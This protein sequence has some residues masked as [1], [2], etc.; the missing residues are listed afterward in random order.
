MKH[1]F[2]I[3]K[4]WFV[5]SS[6]SLMYQTLMKILFYLIVFT[7]S[8]ASYAQVYSQEASFKKL[9]TLYK[10]SFSQDLKSF[11]N[12]PEDF[13]C[14]G[15]KYRYSLTG[16]GGNYLKELDDRFDEV[17]EDFND[18]D[19]RWMIKYSFK[20]DYVFAGAKI[21]VDRMSWSRVKAT[22][23]YLYLC[24]CNKSESELKQIIKNL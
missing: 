1:L 14:I 16:K 12:Y 6:I 21:K 11:S 8:L 23:Y 7:F 3:K 20:N 9:R 17:I 18:L 19:H 4:Q 2:L 10:N 5:D 15:Y 24:S 22:K 13:K